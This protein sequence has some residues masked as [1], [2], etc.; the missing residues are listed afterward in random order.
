MDR[1]THNQPATKRGRVLCRS[2][3]LLAA[4]GARRAVAAAAG[5]AELSAV[6]RP[7]S[8]ASIIASR[9]RAAR[10]VAR[11][12][13]SSAARLGLGVLQR[14][15]LAPP[16]GDPAVSLGGVHPLDVGRG[17]AL[18]SAARGERDSYTGR[19]PTTARVVF[20]VTRRTTGVRRVERTS[21][22]Q[23][24]SSPPPTVRRES[25][26]RLRF[27]LRFAWSSPRHAASLGSPSHELRW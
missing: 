9:R 7:A 16:R 2:R 26:R 18:V 21:Q 5:I 22:K 12:P 4:A 15:P 14:H 3:P 23:E 27:C 10:I 13:S 19:P 11:P 24:N 25:S 8:A 1:N 17:R 20:V 6:S